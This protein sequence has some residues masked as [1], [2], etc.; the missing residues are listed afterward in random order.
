MTVFDNMA[1]GLELEK[2]SKEEIDERVQEA[3]K[4]L[5]IE[6][7]LSRK[8]VIIWWSKTKGCYRKSYHKK[9]PSI[10]I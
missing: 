9:A 4:I 2:R 6:E 7:Y 5:Q 10:F 1:F 3:A 8:P